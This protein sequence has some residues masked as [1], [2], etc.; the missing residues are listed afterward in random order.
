MPQVRSHRTTLSCDTR[1]SGVALA[2]PRIGLDDLVGARL[3]RVAVERGQLGDHLA[4]R[5]AEL[6]STRLEH[7]G[8][9]VLVDVDTN[10]G[11]IDRMPIPRA[12][13][14]PA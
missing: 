3:R 5:Y 14:N 10:R 6:R 9:S 11:D 4:H 2:A 8:S 1:V 13:A 12:P 7:A